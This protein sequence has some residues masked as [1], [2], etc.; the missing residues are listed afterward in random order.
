MWCKNNCGVVNLQIWSRDLNN[1]HLGA[2]HRTDF[3]IRSSHKIKV[4]FECSI[5]NVCRNNQGGVNLQIWTSDPDHAYL[6]VSILCCHELCVKVE[7]SIIGG[8]K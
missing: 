7:C 8:A 1:A 5:M 3:V 2:I 6:E 4:K